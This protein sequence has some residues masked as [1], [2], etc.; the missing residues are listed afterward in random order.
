M[1][2]QKPKALPWCGNCGAEMVTANVEGVFACDVCDM[3]P[4]LKPAMEEKDRVRHASSAQLKVLEHRKGN[5]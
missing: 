4:Y 5:R 2:A 3:W 1:S